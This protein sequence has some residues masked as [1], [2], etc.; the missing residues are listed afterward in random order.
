MKYKVKQSGKTQKV[1]EFHISRELVCEELDRIYQ[2]MARTATLPGY[3]TGKAP[4][5][6]IKSRYKQEVSE[7]A[8]RNLLRSSLKKAMDE[9]KDEMLGLPEI[10]DIQFDEERGMSYKA[11]VNLWPQVRLKAYKGLKLKRQRKSVT[12]SDVDAEINNLRQLYATYTTKDGSAEGG[13]YIVGRVECRV[14]EHPVE[15]KENVWLFVGDDAFLPADE[16][17][18]LSVNAKKSIEKILPKDYSRKEVAG[19]KATFV[20]TV[21]EIKKKLLPEINDEFAKSVASCSNMKEFR[22]AV[23]SSLQHRGAAEEARDLE[24]Q[25]LRALDKNASF[26]VPPLMVE[27]Q[28]TSLVNDAKERLKRDNFS[29]EEIENAQQQMRERLKDEAVRQVRAFFILDEIARLEHIV[30][31]DKEVDAALA[32]I[33]SSSGCTKEDARR[34]YEKNDLLETLRE[35]IKQKKILDFVIRHANIE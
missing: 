17:V 6:L 22:D 14:G 5:K 33:A 27:R 11:S 35:D 19:K 21:N 31:E 4:L 20:V 18:G 13:D 7:E 10:T 8:M 34:Y 25:A 2:K 15:T 26:E 30:V 24:G 23:R 32:A 3:R 16:L 1:F 29:D 28:L 12:E 9:S